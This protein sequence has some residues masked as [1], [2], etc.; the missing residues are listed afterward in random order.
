MHQVSLPCYN[1]RRSC[2]ASLL[3]LTWTIPLPDNFST[4]HCRWKLSRVNF[5]IM[6]RELSGVEKQQ[7]GNCLGWEKDRRG[8]VWDGK[9]TGGEL[10]WMGKRP[11]GNCLGWEKDRRGIVWDGKKTGGELSRYLATMASIPP[12]SQS[13]NLHQPQSHTTLALTFYF[14]HNLYR[15]N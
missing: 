3:P 11:E 5:N 12:S 15:S 10:S 13:P 8:I 2:P 7:E 1:L 6:G 4:H 14:I 9:K